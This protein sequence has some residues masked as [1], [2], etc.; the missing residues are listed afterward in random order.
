MISKLKYPKTN[1]RIYQ[2]EKSCQRKENV[3]ILST[4]CHWKEERNDEKEPYHW[5]KVLLL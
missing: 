5:R 1:Y 3:M 4:S 2:Q